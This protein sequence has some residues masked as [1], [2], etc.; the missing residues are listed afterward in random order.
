[1]LYVDPNNF[2]MQ[3]HRYRFEFA[4]ADRMFPYI[5]EQCVRSKFAIHYVIYLF[6]V[7]FIR[8][9]ICFIM[10]VLEYYLTF[11]RF[12]LVS[13]LCEWYDIIYPFLP[14]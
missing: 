5:I 8:A 13:L 7:C 4:S 9:R 12:P 3:P 1:M 11:N 14:F 2:V 6:K 10:G